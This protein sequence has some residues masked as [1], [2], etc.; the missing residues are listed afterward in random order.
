MSPRAALPSSITV[1]KSPQG[2]HYRLPR[3]RTPTVR[4]QVLLMVIVG[5]PLLMIG[6]ILTWTSAGQVPFLV[7]ILLTVIAPS[8]LGWAI[9]SYA[10]HSAV[11]LSRDR[12]I[13]T[14]WLGPFPLRRMRPIDHLRRLALYRVQKGEW[15]KPPHN[16]VLEVVCEGSQSLWFAIGYPCELLSSVAA[17]LAE[18]CALPPPEEARDLPCETRI[19]PLFISPV[20]DEDTFDRLEQPTGSKIEMSQQAGG[21]TVFR[22]PPGPLPDAVP[23]LLFLTL[24]LAVFALWLGEEILPAPIAFFPPVVVLAAAVCGLM[25]FLRRWTVIAVSREH[26]SV[27]RAGGPVPPRERHWQRSA[28][29]ELRMDLSPARRRNE[30]VCTVHVYFHSGTKAGMCWGRDKEELAWLATLLREALE[31]PPVAHETAALPSRT[32]L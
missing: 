1:R 28:I 18:R 22:V 25:H 4:L 2:L 6:L 9:A 17:D 8:I 27:L 20:R 5:A 21:L 14:E 19:E 23:I 30:E 12:L 10:C 11:E 16:G 24:V 7:G 15:S 26:L 3:R 13:L 29:R 31:V 32:H